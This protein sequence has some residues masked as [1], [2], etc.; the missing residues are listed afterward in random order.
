MSFAFEPANQTR[1]SFDGNLDKCSLLFLLNND[2][3]T[4]MKDQ[5]QYNGQTFEVLK[6]GFITK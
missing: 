4:I 1:F 6:E 2:Y 5:K 3:S